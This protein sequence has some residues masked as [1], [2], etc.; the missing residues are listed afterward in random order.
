MFSKK[1]Q[2]VRM[3]VWCPWAAAISALILNNPTK[4]HFG[5]P[6]LASMTKK[7]SAL[8]A[9]PSK[10]QVYEVFNRLFQAWPEDPL[11]PGRGIRNLKPLTPE[12]PDFDERH[13]FYQSAAMKIIISNR[14]GSHVKQFPFWRCWILRAVQVE[15]GVHEAAGRAG[16]LYQVSREV[17]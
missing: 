16:V 2:L 10:A 15:W 12:N 17:G 11:R 3:Y 13:T 4:S 1:S 9:T 7:P 8:K 14:L 6:R 5:A